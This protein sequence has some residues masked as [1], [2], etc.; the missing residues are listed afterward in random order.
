MPPLFAPI[1]AWL[2]RMT[3]NATIGKI[4]KR[5]IARLFI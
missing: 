5:V 1:F 2:I 3:V 4:G